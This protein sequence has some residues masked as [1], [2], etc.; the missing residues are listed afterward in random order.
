MRYP[1]GFL[2]NLF[3]DGLAR[4]SSYSVCDTVVAA[5]RIRTVQSIAKILSGWFEKFFHQ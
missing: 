2:K 1:L 3:L 4:R 5:I